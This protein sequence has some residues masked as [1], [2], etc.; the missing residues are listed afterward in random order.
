MD[1]ITCRDPWPDSA[2]DQRNPQKREKTVAAREVK[3][4]TGIRPTESE[5]TGAHRN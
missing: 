3:G 4:I 1:M 5:I 2:Q